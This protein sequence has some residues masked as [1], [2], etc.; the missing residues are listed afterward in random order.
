MTLVLAWRH[1]GPV[2]LAVPLVH[3][4]TR[5]AQGVTAFLVGGAP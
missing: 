3:R 5:F 4:L 1:V 2:P